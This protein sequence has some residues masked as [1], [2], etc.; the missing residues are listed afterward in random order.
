MHAVLPTGKVGA[1]T[2]WELEKCNFSVGN[3]PKCRNF[4]ARPALTE[5]LSSLKCKRLYITPCNPEKK[6]AS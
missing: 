5:P 1:P 4:K 2:Q 3:L 6:L